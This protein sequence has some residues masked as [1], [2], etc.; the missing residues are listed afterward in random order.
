MEK[1]VTEALQGSLVVLPPGAP[2]DFSRG[3]WQVR[4]DQSCVSASCR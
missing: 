3:G 1:L 2:P 4:H